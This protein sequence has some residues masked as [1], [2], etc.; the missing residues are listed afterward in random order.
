MSQHS[1]TEVQART[2]EVIRG[3]RA[4]REQQLSRLAGNLEAVQARLATTSSYAMLS[5]PA[6]TVARE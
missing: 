1:T 4:H 6:S 2:A 3:Y 5:Q